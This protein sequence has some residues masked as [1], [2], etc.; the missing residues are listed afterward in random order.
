MSARDALAQHGQPLA[1][2][3]Y[4]RQDVP[5]APFVAEY[6]DRPPP[7]RAGRANGC[8]GR[9]LQQGVTTHG[10][11]R[12]PLARP[13]LRFPHADDRKHARVDTPMK[14]FRQRA[15]PLS[16]APGVVSMRRTAREIESRGARCVTRTTDLSNLNTDWSPEPV[17]VA[18]DERRH[19]TICWISAGPSDTL[20]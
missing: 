1:A 11:P 15:R 7:R 9:R 5:S 2:A 18:T 20:W 8:R 12:S 13:A 3:A 14:L 17:A 4:T 10:C 19:L 16:P 6:R